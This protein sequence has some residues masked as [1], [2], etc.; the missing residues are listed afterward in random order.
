MASSVYQPAINSGILAFGLVGDQEQAVA[1]TVDLTAGQVI[2]DP[3]APVSLALDDIR[4]APFDGDAV[5]AAI[6]LDAF[7]LEGGGAVTGEGFTFAFDESAA[8]S[9]KQDLNVILE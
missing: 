9:C 6:G 4:A 5:G 2:V 8:D 1:I 3:D 7:T